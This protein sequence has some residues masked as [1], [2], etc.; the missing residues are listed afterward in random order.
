[1]VINTT[2]PEKI[3]KIKVMQRKIKLWQI[4]VTS[5]CWTK[6]KAWDAN[7]TYRVLGDCGDC[8]NY[9]VALHRVI[10]NSRLIGFYRCDETEE[11]KP[12]LLRHILVES[13]GL[14]HD[15]FGM[16]DYDTFWLQWE[17]ENDPEEPASFDVVTLEPGCSEIGTIRFDES[18]IQFYMQLLKR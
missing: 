2:P 17:Q 6:I 15:I 8:G 18:R 1:M 14:L 16:R 9:A 7:K 5:E 13:D 11:P 10:P 12:E 3:Q 4:R